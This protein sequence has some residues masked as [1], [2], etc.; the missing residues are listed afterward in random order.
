MEELYVLAF[1]DAISTVFSTMLS[2]EVQVGD[3]VASRA[4]GYDVSGIISFS[5]EM[6]GAAALCFE[7]GTAKNL[8]KSFTGMEIATDD[9]DF[10]DAIGELANMVGGNA[11][12]RFDGKNVNLSCPS[13]VIGNGHQIHQRKDM[14][15]VNLPCTCSAGSFSVEVTLKESGS[16]LSAAA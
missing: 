16:E 10:A 7:A 15:L 8:V 9:P 4:N 6:V 14:P 13:V 11:K 2:V 12:S 3:P 5:G 1:R